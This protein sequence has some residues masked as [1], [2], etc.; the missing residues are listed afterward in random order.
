MRREIEAEGR[1]REG[2]NRMEGEIDGSY[3]SGPIG[4]NEST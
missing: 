2:R 3:M 4:S 1:I